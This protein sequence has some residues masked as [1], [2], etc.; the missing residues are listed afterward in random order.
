MGIHHHH[1]HAHEEIIADPARYGRLTKMASTLSM[2]AALILIMMK[3]VAWSYTDSMSMM[4]S[5]LDSLLDALAS[6]V[7]FM[8]VRYALQPADKE[9]RFGHGKA[10]EIAGLAQATFVA[11]SG[12]FL[13]IESIKRL[14]EPEPVSHGTIGIAVMVISM[15]VTLVLVLFQRYVVAQTKSSAISADALHYVT[16]FLSNF[17]VIVALVLA[18]QFGWAH[19]DPLIALAVSGYILYGAWQIGMASFQN[20]MDREFTDEERTRIKTLT[21]N[22]PGVLGLHDLRTR[23]AGMHSFI[24]M[25]LD[26]DGTKTLNEAHAIS[27]RVEEVLKQA[28]PHTSVIIHEDPITEGQKPS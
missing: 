19:A 12:L 13:C 4:S 7:N 1:H 10:E 2:V 20:L 9:H 24:Q 5:L 23:K 27:D 25:H 26:L 11:G 22:Q 17:A 16:D 28:F 3:T 18:T 15:L 8:A 21:L 14:V 6:A